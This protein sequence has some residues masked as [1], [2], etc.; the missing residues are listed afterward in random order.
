MP[1]WRRKAV[2]TRSALNKSKC[3]NLPEVCFVK[4]KKVS[5][6]CNTWLSELKLHSSSKIKLATRPL[7]QPVTLCYGNLT[8]HEDSSKSRRTKGK[9]LSLFFACAHPWHCACH[10]DQNSVDAW[11][12]PAAIWLRHVR[13]LWGSYKFSS[14]G[15]EREALEP[16]G[17][18][19]HRAMTRGN[20]RNSA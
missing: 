14:V 20:G 17:H 9:S 3:P 1:V 13:G 10:S 6:S 4:K 19:G 7:S 5:K 11:E 2:A 18:H 12:I 15:N 8:G 16:L